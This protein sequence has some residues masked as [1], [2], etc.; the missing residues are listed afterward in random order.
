MSVRFPSP[1]GLRASPGA[2]RFAVGLLS[3]LIPGLGHAAL[4]RRRLAALFALPAAIA[5]LMLALLLPSTDPVVLASRLVDPDV[6]ALLI[7]VQVGILGWRL[8]AVGSSVRS[9]DIRT[10][11]ALDRGLIAILLAIVVLPQA[12][13]AYA[14]AV[15]REEA[16][17]IF[18]PAEGPS[19]WVPPTTPAPSGSGVPGAS[20]SAGAGP[21]A[22]PVSPRVTVLLIGM[23]SGVGRNTALTD[24]MMVASLDPVG[25][26]VSLL[27]IPRDMVDVP[28]P[29]GRVYRGKINGLVSWVRWHPKDFPGSHGNGQAVLAA[30]VSELL[31]IRIDHWAQV[32]LRGFI[33]LVDSMGGINVT[34]DH[35]FCD[36]TYDEYGLNGFGIPAGRWHL[37]G[38]KALAYARVRKAAGESDFTRAARQQQVIV[39]IRDRLV[40]GGFL[41]DPIGFLRSLGDTLST[42]VPPKQLAEYVTLARRIDVRRVY[43]ALIA[44]PLVRAGR[45]DPRGSIQVPDLRAI[46]RLSARLFPV[47][48]TI[49]SAGERPPSEASPTGRARTAPSGGCRPVPVPRPTPRPTPRP[50]PRPSPSPEPSRSPAPTDSPEPS[51]EPTPSS[52]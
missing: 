13:L 6:L 52:S 27:S 7:V 5:I 29:D 22:T 26:T 35:A 9:V 42:T 12:V 16:L 45:G 51:A 24:T 50:S 38:S 15:A 3:A 11:R 37:D 40:R 41:G 34:V 31:K 4:G 48:G 39:A 25:R 19:V 49:P 44:H 10:P 46:R 21:S 33:R 17:A 18:A 23:D 36:A 20:S 1:D 32:D 30:A 28:L 47:P 8:L 14:T 2:R 43:R